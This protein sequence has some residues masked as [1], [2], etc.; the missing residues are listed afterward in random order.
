[1]VARVDN[2]SPTSN[3]TIAELVGP[4]SLRFNCDIYEDRSGTDVRVTTAWFLRFPS[5]PENLFVIQ[6]AATHPEFNISGTAR[7]GGPFPTFRNSLTLI[8]MTSALDEVWLIC[9]HSAQG[10]NDLARWRLRAYCK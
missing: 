8:N 6:S 3:T 1:M 2:L 4:A 10:V 5:N 7:E 9:G